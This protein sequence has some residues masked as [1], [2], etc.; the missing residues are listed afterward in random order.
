[1]KMTVV[2]CRSKNVGEV[3]SMQYKIANWLSK[4]DKITT[5]KFKNKLKIEY[6]DLN[7]GL[8]FLSKQYYTDILSIYKIFNP[9]PDYK[10]RYIGMSG[11]ENISELH[12]PCSWRMRIVGSCAKYVYVFG[13]SGEVDGNFLGEVDGYAKSRDI[14]MDLT[15]YSNNWR[16]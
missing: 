5:N 9:L 1:M 12:T 4:N 11:D 15:V 16:V 2:G 14:T 10:T 7:D 8:D 6:I 3:F 13:K